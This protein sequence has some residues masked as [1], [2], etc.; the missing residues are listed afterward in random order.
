[1]LYYQFILFKHLN[2]KYTC[3]EQSI[4]FNFLFQNVTVFQLC[5]LAF[6]K[7]HISH[8]RFGLKRHWHAS[9]GG[10]GSGLN[11]DECSEVRRSGS[12]LTSGAVSGLVPPQGSSGV[13]R[14]MF[15]SHDWGCCW[16]KQVSSMVAGWLTVCW[17]ELTYIPRAFHIPPDIYMWEKAVYNDL[18]V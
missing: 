4:D 9:C 10:V 2:L 15:G 11:P 14:G 17:T 6:G 18:R 3:I 5:H 16:L 7:N 1:M 8:I 12:V 13:L